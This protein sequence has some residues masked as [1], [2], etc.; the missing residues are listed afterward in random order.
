MPFIKLGNTA[1][2]L[3]LLRLMRVAR[4]VQK[5]PKLRVLI[6]VLCPLLAAASNESNLIWQL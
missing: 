5:M 6:Q 4:L 1:A 3:R 2:V